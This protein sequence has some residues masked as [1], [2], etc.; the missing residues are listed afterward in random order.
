MDATDKYRSDMDTLGHFIGDRCIVGPNEQARVADLWKKYKE[1]SQDNG[2]RYPMMK[3]ALGQR[4]EERGFPRQKIS[5]AW[6][7]LGI[8]VVESVQGQ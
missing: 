8:G 1:W 6:W 2:E 3:R 5:N 7:R 4:L